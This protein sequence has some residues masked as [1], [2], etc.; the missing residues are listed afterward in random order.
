MGFG[1]DMPES[2]DEIYSIRG[3]VMIAV[4]QRFHSYGAASPKSPASLNSRGGRSSVIR[5]MNN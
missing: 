4:P 1:D 5:I 2:L 3:Y